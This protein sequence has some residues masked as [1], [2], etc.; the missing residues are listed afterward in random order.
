MIILRA[1]M[2][3]SMAWVDIA[4]T[5]GGPI[6]VELTVFERLLDMDGETQTENLPVSRDFV[7]HPSQIILQPGERQRV[8]VMYR[9]RQRVT[10]DK[11]WLLYSKEVPLTVA[12]EADGVSMGVTKL[13]SYYSILAFETGRTGRLSFVSSRPIGD[14]KIEVIVENK[15]NGRVVAENLVITIGGREKIR[16]F[17]GTKNSV[18]PGQQRRFTF[19]YGR[20]LTAREVT[21]GYN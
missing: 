8:Q 6:A 3:E 2:G 11:A 4:H 7:V 19:E 17:T 13:V 10:A 1:N 9:G 21:F 15:S 12:E 18:M 5:G 20:P 14:G 16:N